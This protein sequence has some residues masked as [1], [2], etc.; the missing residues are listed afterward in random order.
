MLE[1]EFAAIT[2]ELIFQLK[3]HLI[4]TDGE[5]I[6]NSVSKESQIPLFIKKV[7]PK[8]VLPMS[9]NVGATV[10]NTAGAQQHAQSLNGKLLILLPLTQLA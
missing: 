4:L 6:I 5:E 3:L 7:T 2:S 9:N 10:S 1:T 8:T